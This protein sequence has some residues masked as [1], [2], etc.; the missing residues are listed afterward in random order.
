[1]T[2][3]I[4]FRDFEPWSG[5]VDMY[6]EIVEKGKDR[7]MEALVEEL[8]PEG[9]DKTQL[10]DLLWFEQDWLREQ[11]GLE[12]EEI[13][14]GCHGKGKKKGKKTIESRFSYGDETSIEI[15]HNGK[16][17]IVK[18]TNDE[19]GWSL[20]AP[21]KVFDTMKDAENSDLVKKLA[22]SGYSEAEGN[23]RFAHM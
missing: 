5:A 21:A 4:N 23:L 22:E 2:E 20:G 10:N 11:L 16:W 6:D 3:D 14:S 12:S 18:E 1:M 9:I 8:Y 15:E 13:E 17:E 7:E 19:R